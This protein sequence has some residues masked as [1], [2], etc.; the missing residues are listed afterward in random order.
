MISAIIRKKVLNRY[1]TTRVLK[2]GNLKIEY[3]E[4]Y[5]R[6]SSNESENVSQSTIIPFSLLQIRRNASTP[7]SQNMLTNDFLGVM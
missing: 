7:V 5:A 6:M 1:E 4:Y 2:E 3:G